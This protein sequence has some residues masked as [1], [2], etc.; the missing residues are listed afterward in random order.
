ML[1]DPVHCV[2]AAVILLRSLFVGIVFGVLTSDN[3]VDEV[4]MK[5]VRQISEGVKL[6]FHRAFDLC[7][8][9]DEAICSVIKLGCDRLLTSG[10]EGTAIAGKE[11][12]KV[13]QQKYGEYIRI[14]AAAGVK[15]ENARSLIADTGILGVHTGSGVDYDYVETHHYIDPQVF[16]DMM[17][18]KG[19][20]IDLVEAFVNK[21]MKGWGGGSL[22]PVDAIGSDGY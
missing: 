5:A 13:L 2:F 4:R 18:W 8:N 9:K 7:I 19:A 20:N 21:C 11:N 14:I 12:L 6:T 15:I 1:L 3:Q 16:G 22:P 10:Q 17:R